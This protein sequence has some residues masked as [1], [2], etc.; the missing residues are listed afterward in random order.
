MYQVVFLPDHISLGFLEVLPDILNDCQD[1]FSFGITEGL[2]RAGIL[3][4][5]TDVDVP[6]IFEEVR[7]LKVALALPDRDFL[8]LFR[9]VSL[10]YGAHGAR[11]LFLAVSSF[12][13]S[14]PRVG[15]LS[16][17]FIRHRIIEPDP[18]YLRQRHTLYHLIVC[19]IVGAFLDMG[20]H[21]DRGCLLDFNNFTPDIQR[22]VDIGYSFCPSCATKVARHPLGEAISH[23]CAALKSRGSLDV[24]GIRKAPRIDFGAIRIGSERSQADAFEALC[25]QLY[26]RHY[27]LGEVTR[28]RAPDGGI[29]VLI[30]KG[31]SKVGL[32]CKYFIGEFGPTQIIQI[33]KSYET[34][35]QNYPDIREFVLV[36]PRDLTKPQSEKVLDLS[37]RAGL[38]I[39][40]VDKNTL[41][42][43]ILRAPD[44]RREFFG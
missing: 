15:V 36:L 7:S 33:Q 11:N 22:K 38:P 43:M 13:E 6:D 26:A 4:L 18:M 40:V 25:A 23:I 44:I 14:P 31:D 29:D 42:S 21:D 9:D 16:T 2:Y 39:T 10:V 34:A 3:S 20:P 37:I 24:A 1:E 30:T 28:I 27:D 8:L 12:S 5:N 19:A 35:R 32:Q 41:T 17:A